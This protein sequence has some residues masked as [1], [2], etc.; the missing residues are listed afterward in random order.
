MWFLDVPQ[1]GG[2]TFEPLVG[3]AAWQL[4][5]AAGAGVGWQDPR[6]AGWTTA[7]YSP[8]VE[9]SASPDRVLLT[10]S[11]PAGVPS[12]DWWMAAIRAEIATIRAKYPGAREI[13]LQPVV[14]GPNDGVCY[15]G[16]DPSMPVH[17]SVI[18]PTIDRAIARVVGGDVVAGMSPEVQTCADYMD[19]TGHLA[20]SARPAIGAAIG[21]FYATFSA[22]VR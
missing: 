2:G 16:G 17:A 9:R 6:F 12:V 13:V 8:C 3:D 1:G 18:H 11:T 4:R 20:E 14:G 22:S 19:T 7:P 21:R 15:A 5:A 10:I